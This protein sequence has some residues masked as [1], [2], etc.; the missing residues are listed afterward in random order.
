MPCFLFLFLQHRDRIFKNVKQ[1]EMCFFS[2][3]AFRTDVIWLSFATAEITE[4]DHLDEA[5]CVIWQKINTNY[6]LDSYSSV[7]ESQMGLN[8]LFSATKMRRQAD[9]QQYLSLS[10]HCYIH[11]HCLNSFRLLCLFWTQ[12]GSLVPAFD[13]VSFSVE[14]L[15]WEQ[16]KQTD[17]RRRQTGMWLY[18]LNIYFHLCVCVCLFRYRVC[19]RKTWT[20]TWVRLCV[21]D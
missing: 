18:W 7:T 4:S 14:L 15:H 3:W 5:S 20:L 12:M 8:L 1:E 21:W 9:R 16:T 6:T 11:I 10:N 2:V 19:L 17:P 13:I